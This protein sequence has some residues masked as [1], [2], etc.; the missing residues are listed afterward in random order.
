MTEPAPPSTPDS[1]VRHADG[2][3]LDVDDAAERLSEL[4]R[5]VAVGEEVT[6]TRGGEPVAR[7]VAAARRTPRVLGQDAGTFTIP[8]DFDA[9]LPDDVMGHDS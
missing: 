6:I 2:V 9:P 7:L 1:E 5:R 3:E 8:A 4:L